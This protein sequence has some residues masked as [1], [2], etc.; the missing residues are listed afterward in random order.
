VDPILQVFLEAGLIFLL[1]VTG[2]AIGTLATLMTVQGRKFYAILANFFSALVYVLAIGRVVTNLNNVW[3]IVA[4]CFGVAVGTWVGMLWEQRLS[5]GF[6]EVHLI[7]S[8]KGDALADKLREEGF[9]VTEYVG[10]GRERQVGVVDVIVP[11]KS[12][13]AVIQIAE[14]VDGNAIVTVTDARTV[15]RGYWRYNPRR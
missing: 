2:I 6:A 8:E 3:N 13:N 14:A 10:Q 11:R 9:G 7:S 5:L 4:Y 1:R 12:V 15:Q